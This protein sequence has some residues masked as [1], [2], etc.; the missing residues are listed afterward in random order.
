MKKIG[1]IIAGLIF[2]FPLLAQIEIGVKAGISSLDLA[3]DGIIVQNEENNLALNFANA[4]YGVHFGLYSRLSFLGVFVEPAVI[5]NSSS[6][7]YMVEDYS[8][9]GVLT[10]LK[11]ESY[12]HVDIP[13]LIGYKFSKLRL[14]GGPVAHF[15][16][17]STSEL[18]QISG[19]EQ[20]FSDAKYGYQI[21]GGIDFWRL[22]VDCLYEGNLNKFGDHINIGGQ[23]FNFGDSA[24]RVIVNV[25]LAF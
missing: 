24:S 1:C 12:R 7:N 21:G 18:F 16:L 13:V 20:N 8:E 15:Y 10:T 17:D 2:C 3:S 6:V 19:Y 5:F 11:N 9:G 23:E 14:Q 4:E 22:R 25:G